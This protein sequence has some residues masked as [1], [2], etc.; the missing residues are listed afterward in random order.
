MPKVWYRTHLKT[1]VI[2]IPIVVSVFTIS[3]SL[4][5]RKYATIEVIVPV[6]IGALVAIAVNIT[7]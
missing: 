3:V 2:I 7:Y 6:I 1:L 4:L 5:M